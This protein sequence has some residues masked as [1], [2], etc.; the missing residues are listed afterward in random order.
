[1]FVTF[2]I[3][4][5][6]SLEAFL[7]VGILMAYLRRLGGERYIKWIWAGVA[8]GIFASVAAAFVLQVVV[9]QFD[10]DFFRA[11]LS[12][13]IMVAA[14]AI[15][16]YMA[17]WMHKQARAHTEEAK[18]QLEGYLGA[19]NMFGIAT[20]AF[21]SVWREGIETVLFLSALDYTG[22][23]PSLLGGLAGF[24]VAVGLIYLLIS[25]SRR[26]PIQVFFRYTS[27]LLI[28]IA[29]GLLASAAS[30]LQSAGI[31]PGA[32]PLFDLS[33]WLPDGEG[34]G[35]FLRGLVGYNATPTALQFALW[36]AYL[37]VAI[38]AWRR[39]YAA[40]A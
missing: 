24:V 36:A 22:A 14:T 7:L 30:M 15:L 6:E 21:F 11:M 17:I 16:T 12:A 32:V 4:F 13:G 29:A 23:P 10:S 2:L 19:G 18:A 39:G 31:L 37:V 27:L 5:R 1:M 9:S 33:G 25:G 26:L 40:K 20:L 38:F 28:V 35:V 8:G 34:I 3:L